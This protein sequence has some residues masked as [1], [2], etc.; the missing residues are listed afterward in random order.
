MYLVDDLTQGFRIAGELKPPGL[1]PRILRPAAL[2]QHDLRAT[3]KWSKHVVADSCRRA[4]R[5]PDIVRAVWQETMGQKDKQWLRGPF[6]FDEMDEKYHGT[7]IA[8]KRVGVVQGEK[9]RAV[10]DLSEFLVNASVTET[11]KVILDAVDNV[12]ATARFLVGSTCEG[13]GAFKLPSKDGSTFTGHLH[14]DFRSNG[15]SLQ[16]FGRA[17]DLK[18]AYKQLARHPEDSWA[19]VL[20]VLCPDDDRVYFFEAVALPFGGVSAVTGFNRAARSLKLAMSR[21]LWLINT[22]YYDD[23]CQ[24]EIAGLETSAADSAERFLA[25]LGWEIARGDKLKP[26]SSSFNILGVTISFDRSVQGV[27]EVW[28]EKERVPDLWQL[29]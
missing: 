12:V 18:S 17:L 27:I 15:S 19:T 26:F 2:S 9:T 25:L 23:F 4:S 1:F 29:L 28:N 21:L 5:D 22:S 10:D 11:D 8:S 7:W 16:L 24:M 13:A 3:A 6:T 14:E 20:A